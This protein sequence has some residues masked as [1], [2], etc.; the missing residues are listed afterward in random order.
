MFEQLGLLAL[1][2]LVHHLEG[3]DEVRKHNL[4]NCIVPILLLAGSMVDSVPLAE[5]KIVAV[6]LATPLSREAFTL[7]HPGKFATRDG[8]LEDG[9]SLCLQSLD[10]FSNLESTIFS[11]LRDMMFDILLPLQLRAYTVQLDSHQKTLEVS[12]GQ[13]QGPEHHLCRYT[14]K[15]CA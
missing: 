8:R 14:A 12:L 13:S 10:G 15:E 5:C 7:L 6:I 11:R 9:L 4:L 3:S 2:H 1:D